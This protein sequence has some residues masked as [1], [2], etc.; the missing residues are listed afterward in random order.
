MVT[1][2]DHGDPR[3]AKILYE[4]SQAFNSKIVVHD[5]IVAKCVFITEIGKIALAA[6]TLPRT[7][8]GG[9]YEVPTHPLVG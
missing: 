8:G 9:A 1:G 4:L 7:P 2:V 6:G 5:E 3:P